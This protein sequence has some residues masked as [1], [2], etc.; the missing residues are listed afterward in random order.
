[1]RQVKRRSPIWV[2][3]VVVVVFFTCVTLALASL[4][5]GPA[6]PHAVDGAAASCASCHPTDRLPASHEGRSVDGCR[7]CHSA[8]S[9]G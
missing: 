7:S 9:G 2:G 5:G 3:I 1:M 6:I 4:G 8:P